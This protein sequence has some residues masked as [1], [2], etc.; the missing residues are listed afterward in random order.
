ME[1]I[2]IKIEFVN[3][4]IPIEKINKS[5]FKGGFDALIKEYEHLIGR[6]VWFDKYLLRIGWMDTLMIDGE[7]DFWKN[8][9]L[10]PIEVRNNTEFWRD[11]FAVSTG[12]NQFMTNCDW[13][14]VDYKKNVVWLKGTD[15]NDIYPNQNFT[16]YNVQYED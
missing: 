3:L 12:T 1:I 8:N 7:I 16:S 13:I 15:P 4:I 11:L 14:E 10:L 5:N 6:V 2:A 9:G